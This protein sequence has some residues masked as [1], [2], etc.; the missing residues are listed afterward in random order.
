MNDIMFM[1]IKKAD[2]QALIHANN[3][4]QETSENVV[5][6]SAFLLV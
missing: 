4:P 3:D 5:E 2:S 1:H 6:Q